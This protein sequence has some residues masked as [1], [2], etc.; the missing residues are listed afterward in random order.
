MACSMARLI[1]E[2]SDKLQTNKLMLIHA[3]SM[4]FAV[5]FPAVQERYCSWQPQFMNMQL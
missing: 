4:S 5:N 3:S 1:R 2:Q